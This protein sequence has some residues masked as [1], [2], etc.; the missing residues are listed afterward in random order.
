MVVLLAI[1]LCVFPCVKMRLVCY[2]IEMIYKK[3]TVLA[4]KK[5]LNH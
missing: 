2:V 1:I 4:F 3:F 5:T